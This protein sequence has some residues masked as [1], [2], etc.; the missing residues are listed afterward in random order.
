MKTMTIL[1]VALIA[2]LAYATTA[3]AGERIGDGLL[4]AGAGAIVGGP[5]GAVVG[6][7][8]GY[9]AGPHIARSMGVHRH[10]R[11]YRRPVYRDRP[12]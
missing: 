10:R 2:S 6:G 8:I 11:H 7:A 5:V 9:T 3:Q 4:G 12:I 1:G